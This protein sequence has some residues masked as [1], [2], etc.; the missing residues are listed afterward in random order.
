MQKPTIKKVK[1]SELTVD[2]M[3]QRELDPNRVRQMAN[4]LRLEAI[5]T[6]CVSQR[7]DGTKVVIDGGHRRAALIE[8]GEGETS[9]N[10]EVYSN[11]ELADEAALF[12]YRNNTQKVGYLDRFR[13]RLI[14]GEKN[15]VEVEKL[16]IKHGWAVVTNP[17]DNIPVLLSVRKLEQLYLMDPDVADLT[18]ETVTRAWGYAYDAVDYRIL[19]GLARFL[20]RY[21]KDVDANDLVIKL[22]AYNGGPDAL[23]SRAQGL[24]E[25]LFTSQGMAI[26]ELITEAYNKGKK[27]GGKRLP[28]WRA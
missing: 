11:L 16:A 18:L 15:A 28:A 19:D 13:V 21:W 1:A 6:L 17:T 9:V 25:M 8:A 26:A 7:S 4:D 14:E 20:R 23:I 5:G 3:V 27:H 12:R 10:A 22:Q 24:R 2:I